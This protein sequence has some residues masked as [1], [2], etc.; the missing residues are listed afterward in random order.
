M[1]FHFDVA[2]RHGGRASH[3]HMT[4]VAGLWSSGILADRPPMPLADSAHENR[5]GNGDTMTKIG[6][7]LSSTRPGRNGKKVDGC[8]FI[9]PEHNHSTPGVP[10]NA[11]EC[12]RGRRLMSSGSRLAEVDEAFA[13]EVTA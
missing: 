6:I 10:K 2:A 7:T 12:G 4:D 11:V 13:E 9:T 3:S 5:K 8:G 1:I